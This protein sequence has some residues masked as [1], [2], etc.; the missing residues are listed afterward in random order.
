M[1][2]IDTAVVLC[3]RVDSPEAGLLVRRVAGLPLLTRTLLTA[4]QVGIQRFIIVTSGPEQTAL[5][6]GLEGEARLRGRVQWVEPME[7]PRIEASIIL[8]LLPSVVLEAGALRQWLARVVDGEWV[9]ASDDADAGPLAVPAALLGPCIQAALQ[10]QPDLKKFLE[11]LNEQGRLVRLP[12]EGSGRERVRFPGEIPA[13]ERALLEALRSPDDGPVVDRYVNRTVSTLLTRGLLNSRVTPNQVTGMSLLAGLVGAWILGGEGV[14]RSLLGLILFQLSIILDHVD[15]EIARLKFQFSRLGKWLDN[16]SDHAVDLAVIGFLTWRVAKGHPPAYFI[17]LG[18]LAGLGATG[19]F[20]VV[21]GWTMSGRQREVRRT[22][23][24][25]LL[26]RLLAT[27]ANRDGFCLA[28]WL[29]LLLGNPEWF[30]WAL[31]LGANAFWV[32]WLFIYGVSLRSR[33]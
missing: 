27:L 2:S 4:Q 13:V 9:T 24:A 21:F 3:P 28:L 33:P 16:F 20:L 18:L 6:A 12:W 14:V 17:V 25:R 19:A 8:V 1:P 26:A 10:G 22:A 32:A 30:L 11:S 5:R 31:A 23:T 7:D 15:G 29:T